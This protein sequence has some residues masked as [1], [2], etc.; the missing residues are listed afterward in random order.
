MA[1][2]TPSPFAI[3]STVSLEFE[4]PGQLRVQACGRIIWDDKHGKAGIAF[5][6]A[7]TNLQRRFSIWLDEQFY[8]RF[9][10]QFPK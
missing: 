4:V 6:C 7:D 5:T 10:V 3:G 2:A 1:V 9:D 8:T